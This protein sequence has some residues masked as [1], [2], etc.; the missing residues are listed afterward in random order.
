MNKNPKKI[1]FIDISRP[2][3]LKTLIGLF[4]QILFVILLSCLYQKAVALEVN[5]AKINSESEKFD[6]SKSIQLSDSIPDDEGGIELLDETVAKLH[7]AGKNSITRFE[8]DTGRKFNP[9]DADGLN[10]Q[11]ESISIY[12]EAFKKAKGQGVE[13]LLLYWIFQ[14]NIFSN[15]A[16]YPAI[17]Q[18][19]K[20][21]PTR[22]E[23][24]LAY[25]DELLMSES[26][27][28]S[29]AENS[30]DKRAMLIWVISERRKVLANL[31]LINPEIWKNSKTLTWWFNK[32]KKRFEGKLG[33]PTKPMDLLPSHAWAANSLIW[34]EIEL[35]SEKLCNVNEAK[36]IFQ[37]IRVC[38]AAALKTEP[39]SRYEKDI[40][41]ALN[42]RLP[43]L[44]KELATHPE[45]WPKE[46]PKWDGRPSWEIKLEDE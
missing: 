28:I 14:K 45:L 43:E 31:V 40:R 29:R 7:I 9:D 34:S 37:E 33:A 11:R 27:R 2:V 15:E 36:D 23:A 39:T 20:K 21:Y 22:W 42:E 38:A 46:L 4:Y 35:V 17:S 8:K 18:A 1:N 24:I 5:P 10:L 25:G 16:I 26:N 3:P 13:L 12:I 44:E 30:S 19:W 41:K 32:N 6:N